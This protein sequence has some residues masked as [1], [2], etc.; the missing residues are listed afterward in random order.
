M[1]LVGRVKRTSARPESRVAV[2]AGEPTQP[3]RSPH[4]LCR[5][6]G[7]DPGGLRVHRRSIIGVGGIR[8]PF[9]AGIVSAV[10]GYVLTFVG[11]FVVALLV[12]VL[13]DKFG[14]RSNFPSAL[15][16]AAY[17]PT[18]AWVASVF[19]ALPILAVLMVLGLYSFYLFYLGLPILMRTPQDK[20]LGYLLA[21]IVCAII[22]WGLILLLPARLFG[23]A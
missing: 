7:R 21:V 12:N 5:D 10:V 9:V 13:A 6:P 2:I 20:A 3:R 22:V 1:D 17:A 14:G 8:T 16:V 18:A 23:F 19:T 15:K 11:V 4:E